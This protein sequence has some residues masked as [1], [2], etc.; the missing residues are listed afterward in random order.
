MKRGPPLQQDEA[1]T[2]SLSARSNLHWWDVCGLGHQRSCASL[3][4]LN[5]ADLPHHLVTDDY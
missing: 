1:R 5:R 2:H 4:T 3:V